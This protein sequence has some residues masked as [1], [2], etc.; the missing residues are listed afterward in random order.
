[1]DNFFPVNKLVSQLILLLC[2]ESFANANVLLVLGELMGGDG[3]EDGAPSQAAIPLTA[4]A[5]VLA[6]VTMV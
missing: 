6:Q 3:G 1:M 5:I 4:G 2:C